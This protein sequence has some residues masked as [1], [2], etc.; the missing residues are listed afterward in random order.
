MKQSTLE[1]L[2]GFMIIAVA[3]CFLLYAY[4]MNGDLVTS[5]G[6]YNLQATFQNVEGIKEGADIAIAGIKI[7]TV[8]DMSL[9]HNNYTAKLRLSIVEDVKIPRDSQASIVTNGFLG[10]KY[11]SISPGSDEKN[12]QPNDEIQY[13]QSSMN[14]ESLI[15]KFLSYQ[16]NKK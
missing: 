12:L 9:D 10:G 8:E 11:V 7:G 13:T 2:I 5:R 1:T 6:Y 16:S 3:G 14:I 15:N 4:S